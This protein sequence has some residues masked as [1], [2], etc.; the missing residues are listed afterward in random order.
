MVRHQGTPGHVPYSVSVVQMALTH[1]N[2][3]FYSAL[4]SNCAGRVWIIAGPH[5]FGGSPASVV[6]AP[7]VNRL[8]TRNMFI[9]GQ[10]AVQWP[11]PGAVFSS[12]I[13]VLEFN[14]R[15]L[16]NLWILVRRKQRGRAV[17]L[18]GHGLSRRRNSPAWAP[19]VKTWMA[20]R[21]D[22]LVFYSDKGKKDFS[23]LGVPEEKLFVA[24][25]SIDVEGIRRLAAE[26]G[27]GGKDVL[28]IGRLV[29]S[30]KVDLLVDGFA[31]ALKGIPSGTKLIIIGDG[32]E[33]SRLRARALELGCRE[34]VE[35]VGE[36][37]EEWRLAPYFARSAVSISPGPIGLSA[38]HSLAYGVPVLLAD[39]EPHNPEVEVL[40]EGRNC[41]YFPAGDA[42]ALAD[43]IKELLAQSERLS[44]LGRRGVEDVT[45]RY[46]VRSM[47]SVFLECF[48][49]VLLRSAGGRRE[50][51]AGGG[52]R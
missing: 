22:G 37:T 27:T 41:V 21:A 38:I 3:P 20:Q 8:D 9:G 44:A 46:S 49:Y 40:S 15:I 28:F 23:A 19:A 2:L 5:F 29:A 11:L 12:D 32:P 48:E 43:R 4:T 39:A 35:F 14:P 16:S 7:G 24:Y 51:R 36:V 1:Y 26:S 30:K 6:E 45:T 42:D 33:R 10:L 25:N 34:R 52:E 31:R 50:A 13:A 18:W 47:V 17:I